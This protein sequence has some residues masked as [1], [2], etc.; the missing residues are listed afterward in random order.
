M[1]RT[2]E[3]LSYDLKRLIFSRVKRQFKSARKRRVLEDVSFTIERG[4]KIGIIGAN[5]SGKSTILKLIA[6]ILTPTSGKVRVCGEIAP[7]IEL[8][9]GFDADLSVEDNIIYNG[10]LLGH[11]RAEMAARLN[12]ILDFA[13]LQDHRSVPLKALS[14]GMAARLGFAI[15]TDVHPD[16]L[17]VDEV[18]SV[19]DEAFRHRSAER[20]QQIWREHATILLVSHDVG[21]VAAQCQRAIWIEA[22]RVRGFDRAGTIAARYLEDVAKQEAAASG[23]F[24]LDGAAAGHVDAVGITDDGRIVVEGW[25]VRPD[26]QLGTRVAVFAD[27]SLVGEA[28]YGDTRADVAHV[29][30]DETIASGFHADLPAT[31][32]GPGRH[33][34]TVAV[35]D[36]DGDR[37]YPLPEAHVDVPSAAFA[38]L[39][40]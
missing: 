16:V 34:I 33:A 5:G 31:V 11:S 39:L 14:S 38:T 23:A 36:G 25:I 19:G 26:M 40:R 29:H 21:F 30:G 28:V 35:Y 18:L 15:A 3:E 32:F 20:L 27:G 37:Y 24:R 17:L 10:I 7:L 6:G 13:Q 2:Q 22:G 1:R 4:E 12:A 9:A 8:G